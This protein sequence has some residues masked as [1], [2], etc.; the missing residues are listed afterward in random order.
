MSPNWC[1][2]IA[3]LL[4]PLFSQAQAPDKA[5]QLVQMSK[6]AQP[7]SQAELRTVRKFIEHL[8]KNKQK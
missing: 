8:Q 5:E 4:L 1:C 6:Q 3:C 7:L 2:I